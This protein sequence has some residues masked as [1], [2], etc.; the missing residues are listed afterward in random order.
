MNGPRTSNASSPHWDSCAGRL[1]PPFKSR[2]GIFDFGTGKGKTAFTQRIDFLRKIFFFFFFFVFSNIEWQSYTKTVEMRSCL[3][4]VKGIENFK[5]TLTCWMHYQ[6]F[7]SFSS[8]L[9]SYRFWL[10]GFVS[11]SEAGA[12]LLVWHSHIRKILYNPENVFFLEND[13]L[14]HGKFQSIFSDK[15][16]LHFRW[17]FYNPWKWVSLLYLGFVHLS[18][19]HGC[20]K[21]KACRRYPMCR[22]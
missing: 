11:S 3:C 14:R 21:S 18:I 8:F 2:L 6:A 22:K 10:W 1:R 9:V 5:C 19:C 17:N 7:F 12:S 20:H 13:E 16:I 4:F 15:S